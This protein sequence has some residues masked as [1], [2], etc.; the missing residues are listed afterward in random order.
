MKPLRVYPLHVGTITRPMAN[1]CPSIGP[2]IIGDLPLIAWY[3]EGSDK[4]ILVDTGGG[5]P[6]QANPRW[7]PYRR[8]DDQS[9]EKAL[10]KIGVKRDDIDIVI[11]T[12]FHWDHT[13]GNGLFPNTEIIV[14][15]D[16]LRY[17]RTPAAAGDCLP[18]IVEN[19]AYTAVAGDKEIADGVEVFL[20]PGHSWGMQGVL[21][22]GETNRIFLPSDSLPL[23]RNLEADPFEISNIYVDLQMYRESMKKIANLS[24]MIL[25]SHD[26]DVLKKAVYS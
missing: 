12:H 24:A 8:E 9:M 5:D 26:F 18:G 17:A 10:G 16:E 21:V 2:G 11:V 7:L 19:I 22:H 14:Q 20:T 1:F 3:I 13:G 6:L 23:C 4:K 25:P 15:E